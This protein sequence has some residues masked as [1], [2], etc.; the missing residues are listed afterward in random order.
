MLLVTISILLPFPEEM[1]GLS[2]QQQ[3]K[4]IYQRNE[5]ANVV[6]SNEV[7]IDHANLFMIA[8]K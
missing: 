1:D 4:L 6:C 8:V 3:R 5:N 2:K 7:F